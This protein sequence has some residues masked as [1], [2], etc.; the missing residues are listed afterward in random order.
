MKNF[1]F[2]LAILMIFIIQNA[3]SYGFQNEINQKN[4]KD[5]A[6]SNLE[7]PKFPVLN[8]NKFAYT[9]MTPK[10]IKNIDK[11]ID[12]LKQNP[13]YKVTID[14]HTSAEGKD[15]NNRL[16]ISRKRLNVIIDYIIEKGIEKGRIFSNARAATMLKYPPIDKRNNRVEIRISK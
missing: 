9:E 13:E 7:I 14:A 10:M 12:F 2:I 4:Q 15:E 5:S 16:T 3:Y 11:C 8:Y 6:K 1:N